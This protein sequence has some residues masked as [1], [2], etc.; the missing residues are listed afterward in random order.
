[1]KSK[2]LVAILAGILVGAW[3]GVGVAGQISYSM[4]SAEK[5]FV[6][7]P[8]PE[9][10]NSSVMLV[11][12]VIGRPLGLASTIAGTGVFVVTLPFTLPTCSAGEAGW[13]LAGRPAGWTFMRP[14]GRGAPLYEEKGVFRP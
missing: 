1:M 12:A 14:L 4:R 5:G 9:A 2:V 11:D 10:P 13:G 7:P 3:G 8:D 6:P